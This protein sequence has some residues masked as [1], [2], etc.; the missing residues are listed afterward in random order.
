MRKTIRIAL[1]IF[2]LAIG[3]GLKPAYAQPPADN[4]NGKTIHLYVESDDFT[5]FW[6][7]N[8]GVQFKVDSKY[9]YSVTLT[10]RD[11]YQQDFFLTSNG[12]AA[13][14]DNYHWKLTKGGGLA[15]N[16]GA[17]FQVSDFQGHTEM[18]IIIDPAGPLASR[19]IILFEAPKTLNILNPWTT[20]A[21]KLVWGTSKTSRKLSITPDKCGWFSTLLLDPAITSGHFTEVNNTEDYGKGGL[22]SSADYDFTA[23]FA[24][25]GK[26]IWL[27]TQTN[28]WTPAWPNVTGECQYQMAVTVRDFSKNHPDFT[29]D[30]VN[31]D[32]SVTGVVLNAIGPNRKPVVNP[33][34]I[35]KDAAISFANFDKWWVTDSTNANVALRSYESCYDIPMSKTGDGAW[36]YDS[37]RDSPIDKSFSPRKPITIIRKKTLKS[38]FSTIPPRQCLLELL[39][40]ECRRN[41]TGISASNPMPPSSTS[42]GS[43]SIFAAMTMSGSSST[44]SLWWIWAGYIPRNPSPS[45]WGRWD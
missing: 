17:N 12:T 1:G 7:Q 41:E 25:H 30:G 28:T 5:M 32:H 15:I 6:F 44:I 20:T 19:P 22:G 33:A 40:Q 27:N 36:E 2:F 13:V 39:E 45:I 21:P 18:W 9:N 43:S 14:N 23:L 3:I 26:T 42:P 4:L 29:F 34:N 37:Y 8:G 31:G 11:Q 38:L 10:G 24:T 16:Q 35:N